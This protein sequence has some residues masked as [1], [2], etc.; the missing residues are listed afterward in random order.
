MATWRTDLAGDK[1]SRQDGQQE[2]VTEDLRTN[3]T[4]LITQKKPQTYGRNVQL[5]HLIYQQ[6]IQIASLQTSAVLPRG[7]CSQTGLLALPSVIQ[8]TSG[9]CISPLHR[10]LSRISYL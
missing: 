9:A 8:P 7:C 1:L 5:I 3:S 2:K 4:G 10:F 6:R